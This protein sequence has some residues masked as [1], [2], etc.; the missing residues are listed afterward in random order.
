MKKIKQFILLFMV[1]ILLTGC[2][3]CQ[4]TI[5]FS[6]GESA[7]FT[8]EIYIKENSQISIADI[9]KQIKSNQDLFDEWTIKE[10]S[11]KI[12]DET[13]IGLILQSPESI[14]E[15]IAR[16]LKH[17]EKNNITTY[18]ID[19]DI[20][21]NGIDLSEL[22]HYQS[23]LTTLKNNQAHFEMKIKMPGHITKSSLGT[24]DNDVVTIDLYDYLMNGYLPAISITSKKESIDEH[25]YSYFLIG[26]VIIILIILAYY[27]MMKKRKKDI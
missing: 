11:K 15:D 16:N 2:V 18:E 19:L 12:S 25:F 5:D 24:I 20:Q 14:N 6:D 26:I 21:K 3:E 27:W 4:L 17:Y 23:T 22:T 13:Y 10:A 7:N 9:K 8:G 1:A